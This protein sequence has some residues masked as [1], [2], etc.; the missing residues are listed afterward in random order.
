MEVPRTPLVLARTHFASAVLGDARRSKRLVQLLGRI[1]KHPGGSLPDKLPKRADLVA[2]YRLMN[3]PTVTHRSVIQPHL[4]HTRAAIGAAI[5]QGGVVLL[6]HDDTE[7]DFTGHRSLQDDL[8]SIGDGR[9][10]GYIG[11]N[12]LAVTE[13]RC[14]LGLA[15]QILHR[16][17]DVPKGESPK[18]KRDHPDRVSRLWLRGCESRPTT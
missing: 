5:A 15:E 6:I 8:G 12:S 14:V 18:A 11:H 2:F 1:F 16:R 4:D 13:D 9:G 7:L 3:C 10:R 17:R